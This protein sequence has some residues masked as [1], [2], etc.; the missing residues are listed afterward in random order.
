MAVDVSATVLNSYPFKLTVPP[1]GF[2]ILVPNCSPGDPYIL[3]A[4]AFTKTIHI[5]PMQPTI[6][7]VS[8]LIQHLP[9][10][11]T[12]ACPGQESSPLDLLVANYIQ[13]LQ[14][15][16]FVRGTDSPSSETPTWIVDLMKS[17]TIP[18]P[19]AG[20]AF[21]NLIKNFS[22]TDVQFS[23]PDSLAEPGTPEAQPK[24]SALV[25]VLID[26]PEQMNFAIDI[27]HVRANADVFYH[28]NKLGFLDL[29]RWQP[30]NATRLE[31]SDGPPML[32]VAFDIKDAPLQVTDEDTF[33]EAVQALIFGGKSISLRVVADV[34]AE[35]KTSL[36]QFLIRKIPAEG[37]VN[38][39][40][41]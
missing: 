1:L 11:L 20:H 28:G 30:A 16:I 33:S 38:V 41:K 10:E 25:K 13:G 14:T 35:V 40:R 6:L 9:T 5:Q 36:G 17:V 3:V 22:M 7:D 27:P 31:G 18:L 37:K 15:T 26:L 23:L 34:D 4:D 24:I 2:D 12:K 29:K 21:D 39:K 19:F 8:G 32:L